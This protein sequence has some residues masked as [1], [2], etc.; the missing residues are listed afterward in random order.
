MKR[1][2]NLLIESVVGTALMYGLYWVISLGIGL[3][4]GAVTAGY[5]G[6]HSPWS[7]IAFVGFGLAAGAAS[8][9][10]LRVGV[11]TTGAL[12]VRKWPQLRTPAKPINLH[13]RALRGLLM[14][15][16]AE[17]RHLWRLITEMLPPDDDEYW[18]PTDPR[19]YNLLPQ[20]RWSAVG[21]EQLSQEKAVH[22]TY[23]AIEEAY[24]EVGRLE[25]I[26][27]AAW[28]SRRESG[29]M[30]SRPGQVQ[31][32]ARDDKVAHALDALE[33]AVVAIDDKVADLE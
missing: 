32:D 3:G 16:R 30:A 11:T 8:L 25:R 1:A 23:L 18:Y 4:V 27:G 21:Q 17:L 33:K 29:T 5:S 20:G 10:I 28:F 26:R 24:E 7:G 15:V 9:G 2:F 6:L 13:A 14:G 31:R 19:V 22:D 12:L